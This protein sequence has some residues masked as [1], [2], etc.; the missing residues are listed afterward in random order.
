MSSYGLRGQYETFC[1]TA[2]PGAAPTT[3]KLITSL[4]AFLRY[5]NFAG[6]SRD[7]LAL[8]VPAIASWRLARLPRCLSEG[9]LARVIA[10]CDGTTPG[11]LRDRAILLLLSRL[12]LRAGEDRKST[13]LN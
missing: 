12:G 4:R 2:L 9:E 6:E 11:R 1:S 10:A 5:L 3:Q 13:R 7:D 8:A